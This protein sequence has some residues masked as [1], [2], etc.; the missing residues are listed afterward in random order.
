MT[1]EELEDLKDD[2]GWI[3][4]DSITRYPKNPL[5]AEVVAAKKISKEIWKEIK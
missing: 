1:K 5:K 4:H 2:I 3:I